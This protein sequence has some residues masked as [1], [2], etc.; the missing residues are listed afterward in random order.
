MPLSA[1]PRFALVA[2]V[3]LTLLR[4]PQAISR[5]GD[6]WLP[7]V[8]FALGMLAVVSVAVRLGLP[9]ARTPGARRAYAIDAPIALLTLCAA[10]VCW[11]RPRTSREDRPADAS[12]GP[13]AEVYDPCE[14]GEDAVVCSG[15]ARSIGYV[16]RGGYTVRVERCARG[17][18]VGA[19]RSRGE[20]TDVAC[21]GAR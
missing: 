18:C 16:C 7:L 2:L 19:P 4:W 14:R 12:L 13:L 15:V 8:L 10:L 21:E 5:G 3:M 1:R 6:N 11:D 17:A 20:H 9:G